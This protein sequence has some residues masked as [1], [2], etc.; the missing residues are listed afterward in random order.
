MKYSRITMCWGHRRTFVEDATGKRVVSV[1]PACR[2]GDCC[3]AIALATYYPHGDDAR[4][5]DWQRGQLDACRCLPPAWDC[6]IA[7]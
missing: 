2:P 7:I 1:Y 6:A 5:T 3:C 4:E